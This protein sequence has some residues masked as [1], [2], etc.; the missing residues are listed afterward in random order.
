MIGQTEI[1]DVLETYKSKDNQ[2][3]FVILTGLKGSG[4]KTVINEVFGK[5]AYWLSD[6]SVS[7]VRDMIETVYKVHDTVFVIS[8]A[9]SMSLQAKNALLK[10]AEE[11]P[12][13]NKFIMTLEDEFNTLEP[14]RSRAV[15]YKMDGYSLDELEQFY[16]VV[17]GKENTKQD[18]IRIIR[19]IC[20][21][22]GDI[23]TLLSYES[24][25]SFYKYVEKVV[26]NVHLVSGANAFKIAN[27]ISFKDGDGK[28]DL[29]LF[30]R[31]FMSVCIDRFH[32]SQNVE[33]LLYAEWCQVTSK[34]IRELRITGINKQSLFD[35]WL[36]EI[37]ATV[38]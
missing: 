33:I 22:P 7:S 34:Y 19:E 4:K 35:A 28:Y 30:F 16:T 13:N 21:V 10:V 24:M 36:L 32:F 2:F 31:T 14:I 23:L 18:D 12:N 17:V 9:D 3:S 29:R 25:K 5:D 6:I 26:D 15:I 11:C 1:K 20:E 27:N 37:R 38:L 8:D